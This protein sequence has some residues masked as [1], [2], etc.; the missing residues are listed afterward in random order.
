MIDF[1]LNGKTPD[2]ELMP[3]NKEKYFFFMNC[4][5]EQVPYYYS[6][7]I[8]QQMGATIY[9]PYA[10]VDWRPYPYENSHTLVTT[11][12]PNTTLVDKY[13]NSTAVNGYIPKDASGK[14]I[15][16]K[17]WEYLLMK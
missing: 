3:A 14:Y 5:D 9:G 16:D 10:N 4:A 11:I 7:I 1:M 17:A 12:T 13:H 6:K 8:W 15:Y 2:W